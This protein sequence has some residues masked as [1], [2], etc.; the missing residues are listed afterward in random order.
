MESGLRKLDSR[1]NA[2]RRPA[3]LG[4]VQTRSRSNGTFDRQELPKK[5]MSVSAETLP[6]D[7]DGLL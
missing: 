6:G 4:T 2:M 1:R 3:T 5:G 7:A